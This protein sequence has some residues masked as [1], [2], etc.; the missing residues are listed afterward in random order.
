MD[1]YDRRCRSIRMEN[2]VLLDNFELWMRDKGLSKATLKKHRDNIDFYVNEFLLYEYPKH[3]SQGADE[4]GMFLGYWFIRKAMWANAAAVK[5]NATSLKKFYNYM[6]QRGKVD[7]EAVEDMKDR[8]KEDL[9]EWVATVNRY[10]DPLIE[11]EDV[12]QW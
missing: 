9:P 5:S 1:E 8:I 7:R 4:V 10:D 11:P 3:A 6:L 12:W 2:V